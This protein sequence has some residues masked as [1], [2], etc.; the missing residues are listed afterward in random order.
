VSDV[1]PRLILA[2]AENGLQL[3]SRLEQILNVAKRLRLRCS[4]ACGLAWEEARVSAT[5]RVGE[6][7]RHFE[8]PIS[9]CIKNQDKREIPFL[10]SG[11][12]LPEE[13]RSVQPGNGDGDEFDR[14]QQS[15]HNGVQC[16]RR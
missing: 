4:L 11:F 6:K 2:A 7:G 3:R 1:S 13:E 5:G 9:L 14:Q 16:G 15:A 10:D 8:Q 12:F